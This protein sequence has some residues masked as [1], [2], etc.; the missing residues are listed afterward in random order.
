MPTDRLS[1]YQA[2]Q[3]MLSCLKVEAVVDEDNGKAAGTCQACGWE[4]KHVTGMEY[5]YE[6]PKNSGGWDVS[7]FAQAEIDHY[8]NLRGL[9]LKKHVVWA[10]L[11]G[12]L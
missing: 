2:D 10:Q 6:I 1:V 12:L 9:D 7:A 3:L 11:R 4:M 5:G 8:R